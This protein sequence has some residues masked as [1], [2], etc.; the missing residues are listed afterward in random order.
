MLRVKPAHLIKGHKQ[1]KGTLAAGNTDGNYIAVFNHLI[2]IT[3]TTYITENFF[4]IKHF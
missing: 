4:G 2:L 1:S 3:G